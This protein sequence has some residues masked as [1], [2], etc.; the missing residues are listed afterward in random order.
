MRTID[1]VI[2]RLDEIIDIAYREESRMG[3]FPALYRKVTVKVKEGIAAGYFD[4]AARMERLDVLFAGR[5][6][7]A[8]DTYHRGAQPTESWMTAFSAAA[9]WPP[10]VM[11]HLLL[12]I[13]AHIHLDLGIAAAQTVLPG[14]IDALRADF[15]RINVLLASLIEEVEDELGEISPLFERLDLAAGRFDEYLAFF[16]IRAARDYAWNVAKKFAKLSPQDWPAET[17]ALDQEV[18]GFADVMLKPR[19]SLRLLLL[20]ARLDEQKSV[21]RN[22]DI[23]R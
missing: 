8:Y 23:L 20:F 10:T 3:Y 5:Y 15:N 16:G 1:E 13:N 11:Q 22:I 6:F 18:A 7:S 17:A 2:E 14:S 19:W 4:D 21:R 9:S 12:G